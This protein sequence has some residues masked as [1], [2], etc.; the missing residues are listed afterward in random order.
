MT[1][2]RYDDDSVSRPD[3][4]V[5]IGGLRTVDLGQSIPVHGHSMRVGP[6]PMAVKR[7]PGVFPR[8][9]AALRVLMLGALLAYG[10]TCTITMTALWLLLHAGVLQLVLAG[11]P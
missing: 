4:L 7:R 3:Q 5:R 8:P 11:H 2:P 9:S 6:R 1:P 10:L